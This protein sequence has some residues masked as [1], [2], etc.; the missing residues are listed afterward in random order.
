MLSGVLGAVGLVG[1][2]VFGARH[3]SH[4]AAGRMFSVDDVPPRAVAMVLGAKADR[5]RP[6]AFLAARLDLAVDL[7]EKGTI[8]AVLVS[9]DNRAQSNHETTVMRDYLVDRGVP[10]EKVVED[11]AGFDTYDSCVRARDV[12]GVKEMV[13]LTQLYHLERAVT[14]CEDIG[15]D[16][17]GVGDVTARDKFPD[18]YYKG[19]KREWAA[20]LKMEWDL[21]SR[22]K[23][24]QDPFDGTLLEAA[25]QD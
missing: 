11:P 12:F 22:R 2:I 7:Y 25:G 8:R 9:G 6:S 16:A 3:V 14:I 10:A 24:Q 23:P 15:V 20:N 17:V 18:L 21:L 19:E 5:D 1:A 4:V 13:I